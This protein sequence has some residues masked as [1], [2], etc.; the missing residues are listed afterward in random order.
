MLTLSSGIKYV[1]FDTNTDTLTLTTDTPIRN[2][3]EGFQIFWAVST[4]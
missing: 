4:V 3:Q 2:A 1:T